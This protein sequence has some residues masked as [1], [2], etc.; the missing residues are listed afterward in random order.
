MYGMTAGGSI[1][2]PRADPFAKS[3]LNPVN[4]S[5]TPERFATGHAPSGR[6]LDKMREASR[7]LVLLA[8]SPSGWKFVH[9]KNNTMVYEM[10][11]RALPSGVSTHASFGTSAGKQED[12]HIVRGVTTVHSSGD[13]INAVLDLLLPHFTGEYKTRMREIFGH[14]T[15]NNAVV[16]D[17]LSCPTPPARAVD[18]NDP[19][20]GEQSFSED[21]AYS[22]NWLSLRQSSGMNDRLRDLTLLSFQ[23]CFEIRGR[24]TLVRRG[25]AFA[26]EHA[27]DEN[28][29]ENTRLLGV[30]AMTSI[31]FKDIPELPKSSFSDRVHIRNSGFVI[32]QTQDPNA[33]RL[34][35]LLSF[36]PTKL[37]LKN[38]RKFNKWLQHLALSAGN[39]ATMLR[40]ETISSVGAMTLQ[41]HAKWKDSDHCFLCLKVFH[42]FR[43]CHHCRFCGEAVCNNCSGFVM[44][45]GLYHELERKNSSSSIELRS[46]D[47][48]SYGEHQMETRGCLNC[49][50]DVAQSLTRKSSSSI[51]SMSTTSSMTNTARSTALPPSQ[52]QNQRSYKTLPISQASGSAYSN[53][54]PPAPTSP[55]S[56]ISYDGDDD[57]VSPSSFTSNPQ[58]S[59]SQQQ[60]QKTT[61]T[62]SSAS[63]GPQAVQP[64][65]DYSPQKNQY[66]EQLKPSAVAALAKEHQANGQFQHQLELQEQQQQQ[67]LQASKLSLSTASS[68]YTS[69]E[70]S[71]LFASTHDLYASQVSSNASTNAPALSMSELTGDSFDLSNDPDIMALA[72]LSVKPSAQEQVENK[73]PQRSFE[74]VR[75]MPVPQQQ[76]FNQ[77]SH[78]QP[79]VEPAHLAAS[80]ASV[81]PRKESNVEDFSASRIGTSS[82]FHFSV[83]NDASSRSTGVASTMSALAAALT[84]QQ[85][86]ASQSSEQSLLSQSR[87]LPPPLAAM[88]PVAPV[89]LQ[90][91]QQQPSKP[92]LLQQHELQQQQYDFH[93]QQH[94]LPVQDLSSSRVVIGKPPVAMRQPP[95]HHS[96]RHHSSMTAASPMVPLNFGGNRRFSGQGPASSSSASSTTS[97]SERNDMI[98]LAPPPKPEN[99]FVFFSDSKR[100][101]LF[102]R[103]SDGSDMI[104]LDI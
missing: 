81:A 52:S 34:S 89:P 56:I 101:S 18:N 42:T 75:E 60:Q 7:D 71:H 69:R 57:S 91:Q 38:M 37:T 85:M 67:M 53:A 79:E 39:L 66:P 80:S 88:P 19:D 82:T 2:M 43:R 26:R 100:D 44:L 103:P 47:E 30:H 48:S 70:D 40:R 41:P 87:V 63:V 12:Y 97:S 84:Q 23:D 25:R 50:R 58:F 3:P 95:M 29:D 65:H 68:S 45:P 83:R 5:R 104:P 24:E 54:P 15:L 11:G 6:V 93:Q 16:V 64:Q 33:F 98:P 86:E 73:Q 102:V 46:N 28:Q 90:Q 10:N 27:M 78:Q 14:K 22:V 4:M 35:V 61:R 59:S 51:S 21:D 99:E 62:L 31:N 94:Q 13:N 32:E 72:G 17:G 8:T 92:F 55:V 1:A 74:V 20:A 77:Q 96:V 76:Q 49:I 9:E 36:L